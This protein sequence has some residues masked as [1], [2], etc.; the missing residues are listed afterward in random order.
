MRPCEKC[1]GAMVIERAVDMESGLAILVY[2][3]LNC[4]RR[5]TAQKEPQP[6]SL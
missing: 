2:A 6:V 4:G 1:Q 3:C 5:S